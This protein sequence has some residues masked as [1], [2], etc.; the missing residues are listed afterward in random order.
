M[1]RAVIASRR[2]SRGLVAP[3]SFALQAGKSIFSY[4]LSRNFCTLT[5]RL[6]PLLP[7]YSAHRARQSDSPP[8]VGQARPVFCSAVLPGWVDLYRLTAKP[9]CIGRASGLLSFLPQ[10]GRERSLS[11]LPSTLKTSSPTLAIGPAY[12]GGLGTHLPAEGGKQRHG[13][14]RMKELVE[15][16][17]GGER[18]GL[19]LGGVGVCWGVRMVGSNS[20]LP[21]Q[22]S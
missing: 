9:L 10:W 7:W 14:G 11:S 6:W 20:F 1:F 19:V 22:G 2:F 13:L 16:Q 8:T 4:H 21:R 3:L 12:A 5:H 18:Q 17:D 15:I